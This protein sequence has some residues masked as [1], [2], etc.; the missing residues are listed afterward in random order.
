VSVRAFAPHHGLFTRLTL[1]YNYQG[2]PVV[3]RRAVRKVAGSY[4]YFILAVASS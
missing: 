1:H 4:Q 3:D 2:K